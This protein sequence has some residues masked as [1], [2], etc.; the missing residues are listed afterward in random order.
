MLGFREMIEETGD[1]P[2]TFDVP[3]SLQRRDAGSEASGGG[4]LRQVAELV[5]AGIMVGLAGFFLEVHENTDQALCDDPSTLPLDL[6]EPSLNQIKVIGSTRGLI[7]HPEFRWR[8]RGARSGRSHTPA[9]WA[10][11]S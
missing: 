6:L 8:G 11:S 5:H 7:Y 4:C 3:H 9:W 10:Q 1:C 2:L